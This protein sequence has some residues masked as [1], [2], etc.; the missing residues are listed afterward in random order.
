MESGF[1]L[2]F[3]LWDAGDLDLSRG[4]E[5]TTTILPHF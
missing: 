5:I 2:I 1:N 3:L 4:M